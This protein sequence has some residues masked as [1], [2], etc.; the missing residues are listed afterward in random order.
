MIDLSGL[1]TALE[2]ALNA[3]AQ[4]DNVGFTFDIQYANNKVSNEA[5]KIYAPQVQVITGELAPM[6]SSVI[7]LQ[8][9]DIFYAAHTLN[10]IAP[11]NQLEQVLAIVQEYVGKNTGAQFMINGYAG[12]AIYQMPNVDAPF[13]NISLKFG[14]NITLQADYLFVKSGV[15]ANATVIELDGE[16]M[17][18]M[19]WSVR[20]DKTPS[21]NNIVNN[22]LLTVQAQTQSV[23]Y[24]WGM[25]YTNTPVIAQLIKEIHGDKPL[26]QTH[27]LTWYDGIAYTESA[28]KTS[29]VVLVSG[30]CNGAAGDISQLE[31]HFTTATQIGNAAAPPQL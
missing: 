19:N 5:L 25:Y 18:A 1:A 28:P 2:N 22:P 13:D 10:L 20:N 31:V 30:I 4:R 11:R 12:R 29:Q 21:S 23:Q 14:N 3:I 7:P 24:T 15:F 8:G 16:K 17:F 9:L 27:T 26:A 6:P